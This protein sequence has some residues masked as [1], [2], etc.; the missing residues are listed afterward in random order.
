MLESIYPLQSL[1][2]VPLSHNA[3]G[4]T[5]E[6]IRTMLRSP[7][8]SCRGKATHTLQNEPLGQMLIAWRPS[9]HDFL[10]S[11]DMD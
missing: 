6:G 1:A 11:T 10:F 8:A 3:S 9:G 7:V 5:A 4:R 2:T